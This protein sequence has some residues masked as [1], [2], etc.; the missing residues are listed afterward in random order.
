MGRDGALIWPTS[1][2][3]PHN[4]SNLHNRVIKPAAR[5]AG[6]PWVGWHSLRHTLATMLFR[7]GANA[8]QVQGWLGHHSPAFTL[9]RY[10]HLLPED[11]PSA[12]FLPA[13]ISFGEPD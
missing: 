10:V 11:A 2:G 1:T 8:K 5:A 12:D 13:L 6:I 7:S 9:E 4:R 3:M